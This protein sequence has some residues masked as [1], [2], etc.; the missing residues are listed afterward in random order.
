MP[1]VLT[2]SGMVVAGILLLLFIVD[3][4]A[5]WPFKKA[6]L[7]MDIGFIICALA[8]G[9]LSWSSFRELK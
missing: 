6:S 7:M 4:A 3:I 5:G 9:Y 2:I 1:K 8:L